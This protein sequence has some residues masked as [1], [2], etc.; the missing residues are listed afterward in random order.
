MSLQPPRTRDWT[1]SSWLAAASTL[2]R[3]Y[4]LRASVPTPETAG[5][6]SISGKKSMNDGDNDILATVYPTSSGIYC[7]A[8]SYYCTIRAC[9]P[10]THG[11]S[12]YNNRLHHTV[13]QTLKPRTEARQYWALAL[14][15]WEW[16]LRYR[17]K[18]RRKGTNQYRTGRC[19]VLAIAA[20]RERCDAM[21][22]IHARHAR[23][24]PSDAHTCSH[25][26]RR[27]QRA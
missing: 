19:D 24:L 4:E 20:G 12:I 18:S 23:R 26:R 22:R 11:G 15:R 5:R 9:R 1:Q 25:R 7:P 14:K 17:H 6:A 3:S 10:S 2:P 21:G 16:T 13:R 27:D 8:F